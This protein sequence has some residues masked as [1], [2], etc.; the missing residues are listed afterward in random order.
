V[1]IVLDIKAA[2]ARVVDGHGLSA[3]QIAKVFGDIMDGHATPAQI[4]GLLI[5]LRMKGQTAD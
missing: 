5:G 3:D 2:I 1:V 4:G